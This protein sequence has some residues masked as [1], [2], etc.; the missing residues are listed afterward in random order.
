MW[1]YKSSGSFSSRFLNNKSQTVQ[2]PR[3]AAPSIR[4]CEEPS[5][6]GSPGQDRLERPKKA[7]QM[8]KRPAFLSDKRY[9]DYSSVLTCVSSWLGVNPLVWV[10]PAR[11]VH[12]SPSHSWVEGLSQLDNAGH[13]RLPVVGLSRIWNEH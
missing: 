12:S 2:R 10:L 6:F 11:A 5:S 3:I 7:V 9:L 8:S 4:S 13:S 1:S